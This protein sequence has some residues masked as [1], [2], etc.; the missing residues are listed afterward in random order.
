MFYPHL[1]VSNVSKIS[2]DITTNNVITYSSTPS[3]FMSSLIDLKENG[4]FLDSFI[5]VAK[6]YKDQN[7]D[8]ILKKSE[9]LTLFP[10]YDII[11]EALNNKDTEYFLNLDSNIFNAI[12]NELS[13]WD[14][15]IASFILN[16]KT[17][18]ANDL[19]NSVKII[20][21]LKRIQTGLLNTPE[22]ILTFWN[23]SYLAYPSSIF[24]LPKKEIKV[25][26]VPTPN[27][28]TASR[29]NELQHNLNTL[30]LAR[31][32]ILKAFKF[33]NQKLQFTKATKEE[34]QNFLQASINEDKLR[35][36]VLK[37][38]ISINLDQEFEA[39]SKEKNSEE[40]MPDYYNLLPKETLDLLKNLGY[41]D[42]NINVDHTIS[43]IDAQ[44]SEISSEM[45]QYIKPDQQILIG[46][47]LISVNN[48]V[49]EDVLCNNQEILSHCE[50]LKKLIS[51]TPDKTY[52]QILG[53]GNYNIIKQ[54]L[55]RY[56]ADEIAEIEN[57]LK[58][59]SKEK[60]HRN[61]KIREDSYY[62]ETETSEETETNFRTADRFEMSKEIN[63]MISQSTQLEAGLSLSVGYGP[64]KLTANVGYATASSSA[65]ATSTA[66]S[67]AKEV[68]QQAMHRIE[69]RVLEKRAVKNINEVEVINLHKIDNSTGTNH[70][71]GFYYWVDKVYK[72]QIYNLG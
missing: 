14:N 66:V 15:S 17:S 53:M 25:P 33:Q 21:L 46:T 51:E 45:A 32:E 60:T 67:N 48:S 6:T 4:D 35:D 23:K 43:S 68:T 36:N 69:E 31:K 10:Q 1:I 72:N 71:N 16:D 12:S 20:S 27:P 63:S 13:F 3:Q 58:G 64:V 28:P 42:T 70:I 9:L 7:A 49:Y 30:N 44:V 2:N 18:I 29:L 38:D 34:Y 52:V 5:T 57:I 22:K 50:L 61:L 59:E 8:S 39:Y 54:E 41:T 26:E 56:E 40:L 11:L 65:E 55:L 37:H 19:T 24:P 47:T 62:I